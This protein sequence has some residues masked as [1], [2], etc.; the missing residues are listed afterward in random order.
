MKL[1]SKI[2]MHFK[3]HKTTYFMVA[4]LIG[5]AA[6][7]ALSF[8]AGL[9]T[10]EIVE[11]VEEPREK[12]IAIAKA[13]AP[14]VVATGVTMGLIFKNQKFNNLEKAG[15]AAALAASQKMRE[16]ETKGEVTPIEEK[17]IPKETVFKWKDS[18]L[19][20]EWE[21]TY[22]QIL[23]GLI[24]VKDEFTLNGMARY[25]TFL[26]EAGAGKTDIAN[27]FLWYDEQ[28]QYDGMEYMI[29]WY[30]KDVETA[31][32]EKYKTIHFPYEPLHISHLQV[33]YGLDDYYTFF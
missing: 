18:V 12:T 28:F 10:K 22:S 6:S 27:E 5:V 1:T 31:D 7:S 19:G 33:E 13:S 24:A 14:A 30:I 32:G 29:E 3:A 20:C 9:K 11:K 8:R 4:S 17:D 21:A 15:L 25:G 16:L 26:E 2:K 23:E